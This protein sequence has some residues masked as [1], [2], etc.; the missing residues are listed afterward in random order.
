MNT[1]Y[2]QFMQT[3]AMMEALKNSSVSSEDAVI[4]SQEYAK[5]FSRNDEM[6]DLFG[7]ANNNSNLLQK[8]FSGY[9]ETPL[10]STQYFNASVASYV[11]SFAGFMSIERDFDQPNGLFYWFDVL[12]VTDMRSVIPNLGPDNY[13]DINTM[14]GFTFNITVGTGTD[15][16]A[17]VG[18]KII[19][20]TVRIKIVDYTASDTTK[21]YELIDDGQG[22]FMSVAGVI[23]D[24][25]INYLNGRVAFKLSIALTN[26]GSKSTITVVGKEDVTGT[27]CNT[28][29]ASNAHAN[30]KRFIAKMQ[31]L[32]LSTVPDMLVAE[33]NIAA[34]GAMKKATG[35][36]MATFLFTKL[37][38]I[39]TKTINYKL[40][41]T[42]EE[43]YTG[44][45]MTDLN[46]TQPNN[47][48]QFYDYRSRID[49]FDAYMVNVETALAKKAVKGCDI[50][51]YVAGANACN[52]FQKGNV[53]GKWERNNKLTYINDLLGW[54]NGIP[55]L[56]TTDIAEADGHGVFYAIHKTKD[57][58]MAPLARGIY[59]PLTDTPTIGN[60]NNPTQ[61]ASGIYYQEG[62]KYMA[63]EL[64]QK[65]D[66]QYS[67]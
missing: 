65:V 9:A 8:T 13:Q 23:T 54:Y 19:P 58:Q 37:R 14:G 59:M 44:N 30:D 48:G 52:Q 49:M 66:F 39:Y 64:V 2:L 62:T 63:Q 22:N 56:R 53:T 3:P 36:D 20:G 12:G 15:Y 7:V 24:G 34:L 27:P 17:L 46:L 1:Q 6:K 55:V 45:T 21:K 26:T 38:E 10:L 33:Y 35:S 16:S 29:G 51:A 42:L 57:G 32:G 18:R 50:T 47:G 67:L 31:Q 28:I 60:Y 25:T 40:V 61:M 4:R 5:M 11:S 43:G 41:S